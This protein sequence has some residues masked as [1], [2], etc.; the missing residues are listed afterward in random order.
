MK[1]WRAISGAVLVAVSWASGAWGAELVT[2]PVQTLHGELTIVAPDGRTAGKA[3]ATV[4]YFAAERTGTVGLE[5]TADGRA[6]G[7]ARARLSADRQEEAA[8]AVVALVL[9]LTRPGQPSNRSSLQLFDVRFTGDSTAFGAHAVELMDWWNAEGRLTF[10][11]RYVGPRP[12]LEP[13]KIQ[14]NVSQACG[15]PTSA[16]IVFI[17]GGTPAT[18]LGAVVTTVLGSQP[19]INIGGGSLTQD[20]SGLTYTLTLLGGGVFGP[21]VECRATLH[22]LLLG[23]GTV[24]VRGHTDHWCDEGVFTVE[25]VG[26]ANLARILGL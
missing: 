9:A 10:G 1:M 22:L 15:N 13:G 23:D 7:E 19:Q 2:G 25:G 11:E 16:T 3:A 24:D 17:P 6:I 18:V 12:P 14:I 21:P 5:V 4:V 20:S 26:D 8:G